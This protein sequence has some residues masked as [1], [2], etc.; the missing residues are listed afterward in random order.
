MADPETLYPDVGYDASTDGNNDL[1]YNEA[2]GTLAEWTDEAS[3]SGAQLALLDDDDANGVTCA[4]YF[5]FSEV[6]DYLLGGMLLGF[7]TA[8]G[9][10]DELNFTIKGADGG[11]CAHEVYLYNFTLGSFGSAVASRAGGAPGAFTLSPSITG[12]ADDYVDSGRIE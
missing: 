9:A 3:L 2:P 7:T 11:G 6:F 5:D 4:N 8:L 12:G 1:L 10:V